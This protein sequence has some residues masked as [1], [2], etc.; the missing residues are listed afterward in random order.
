MMDSS[1]TAIADARSGSIPEGLWLNSRNWDL[2]FISLSSA[3]VALPFFAY[4]IFQHILAVA[5]VREALGIATADVLDVARN[6]VNGMIALLIGGPHMYATYTRTFLDGEFRKRHVGFLL[7]SLLLPFLVVYLGVSN[8]PLLVTLF[9]FWASIHILHQIAYI[10]D[11][12]GDKQPRALP[13]SARI[14][15]YVVVFSSLYP[16]GVW[17]MV[18]DDFKIGQIRLLFPEFL[19]IENNPVVGWGLFFLVTLVFAA[20]LTLWVWRSWREYQ[21]GELHTPKAILMGLTIV[22]SF[23][24]PSYHELDVAFQGFNTWHS[25]QYL[26]LTLYINRLR[27]QKRGIATPLIRNMSL[28]GRGWTFYLFNVG[29]ALGAVAMIALLLV[30]KDRLGFSFDQCYYVVVLSF[31][32][33]HYYHDHLLFMQKDALRA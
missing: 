26:G 1:T 28:E 12:Y 31:L 32:L 33:M 13:L 4:E 2:T 14:L 18:N 17:R 29:C 5:A 19:M 3:L 30:N 24:I 23:F 16:I 7:G 20:S 22:V 9:F 15:D 8:F 21:R 6:T 27:Q 25:I 11:C 10:I